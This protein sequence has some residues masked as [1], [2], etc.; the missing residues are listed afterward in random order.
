MPLV[1]LTLN[2]A[3]SDVEPLLKEVSAF[4]A[5]IL[6]KPESYVMVSYRH[7]PDMLF[8]ASNTPMAYIEFK[9]IGLTE[10]ITADISAGLAKLLQQHCSINADRIYIEFANA[11]RKMW[12]WN[13]STF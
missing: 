8:A 7:N 13:G 11:P 10:D 2:K 12:G 5:K 9:S 6:S 1:K 4:T 3:P